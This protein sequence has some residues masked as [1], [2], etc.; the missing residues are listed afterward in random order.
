MKLTNK[1]MLLIEP[2]GIE[3]GHPCSCWM[4]QAALLIEPC[5]IEMK[6]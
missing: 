5:G 1:T 3:I 6:K 4:V 2:C